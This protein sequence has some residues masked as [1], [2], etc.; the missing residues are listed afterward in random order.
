[1]KGNAMINSS[2]RRAFNLVS[3]NGTP[4]IPDV[5]PAHVPE[6]EPDVVP[7]PLGPDIP[8]QPE[9]EPDVPAPEHL[10]PPPKGPD[11]PTLHGF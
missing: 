11:Q 8:A 9:P 3:T 4:E 2:I 10:P 5:P 1:M 6:K 7:E